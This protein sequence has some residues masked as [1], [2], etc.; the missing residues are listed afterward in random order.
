[1]ATILDR[2]REALAPD[3]HVE[4]EL[5]KG[6]MGIVFRAREVLLDRPVAI[7]IIRPELATARAADKFL[8]EARILANLRH[9]NV[10]PVHR[11][12]EADGFFYYVMEFIEGN[13][14]ADRLQHGP[15]RHSEALKLGRDLLDALETVHSVGVVHRDIKPSNILLIDGRAVL[16]DFGIAKPSVDPSTLTA[17]PG[18]VVG[19]VGYMPPEQAFGWE[20]TSR[21]DLFAAAAVIYEAYTGRRWGDQMPDRRP[22][23]SGIP[24]SVAPILRRA[25]T[26][27]PDERW[28]DAASFRRKLWKTRTRR[29]R[30][31]TFLLTA[32]GLVSGA[33]A[34]I[35]LMPSDELPPTDVTVLPFEAGEG[36]GTELTERLRG[37]TELYLDGFVTVTGSYRADVLWQKS[38]SSMD[39]VGQRELQD[40]GTRAVVHAIVTREAADTAIAIE[41][42]DR[43]GVVQRA[44]TVRMRGDQTSDQTG[45]RLGQSVAAVLAPNRQYEY[46]GP[47]LPNADE[48]VNAYLDGMFAFKR[49]AFRKARDHFHRAWTIDTTFEQAAWWYHNAHRW[50]VTGEPAPVD[51]KR[52]LQARGEDLSEI[53]SM[54]IE[55][56]L[57]T[58]Q[59][60][61]MAAYE[62]AT[63]HYPR[64]AYA[65]FLYAEE[66]Q[67]RGALIGI[68]LQES[69]E[70]LVAVA[71]MDSTFAPTH[72]HLVWSYIR[73][74]RR[75][76]AERSLRRYQ[77]VYD[78]ADAQPN[79]QPSLFHWLIRERFEPETAPAMRARLVDDPVA[80]RVMLELFRLGSM[81]DLAQTQADLAGSFLFG[82]GYD[83]QTRGN[84][85]EGW[86]LA[87]V[88]LG[89]LAQALWHVDSAAALFDTDEARLEA[90]EWRVVAPALGLPGISHEEVERGRIMLRDLVSDSVS[91]SRAAWALGVDAAATGDTVNTRRW[92]D[93]LPAVH[94]DTTAQQLS[95]SLHSMILGSQGMYEEALQISE[96]MLA[97]DSA[98]RGG[99]PFARAVLHL[100]RA[101]WYDSL[102]QRD[103]AD[104]ARLWYEHFEF[105]GSPK[106]VAHASEIDW[107]LSPYVRFLRGRAAEQRRQRD[108]AC[109]YMSRLTEL[110]AE[111]DSA[112]G[113]LRDE[114]LAYAQRRCR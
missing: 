20:V 31:R 64:N 38:D 7:K 107:A 6:G 98:G 83:S 60:E 25:L 44:G 2:L 5:A 74:G 26:W 106:G 17:S 84:L 21:T 94:P 54:L 104:A 16:T 27:Q 43:S 93:S 22:D 53:D 108:Q 63:K 8:R 61:R 112:Y 85:H 42:L 99:D 86:G 34:V 102:G 95:I 30:R 47:S 15:L 32:G 77:Q 109:S 19:T 70:R 9:P 79:A 91:R 111:A 49:N 66:S 46:R 100:K 29:Y 48:A 92:L 39:L 23:W 55:A 87:L 59:E 35:V 72:Q 51:L 41:V 52:L 45:Y 96:G 56:Q 105:L 3:Y 13:T 4:Q 24:G 33:A 58:S 50:L 76:H 10:V 11:A 40:V 62:A 90:A 68:P 97:Y 69:T 81:W 75:D 65:A 110:W 1:M 36:I 18:R 80:G 28:P 73:L 113:P 14:L 12:G 88:G 37:L 101:E 114:A 89:K 67:S 71:D 103:R 57:A 78:S 82:G